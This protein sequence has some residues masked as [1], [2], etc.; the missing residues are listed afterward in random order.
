MKKVLCIVLATLALTGTGG[1]AHARWTPFRKKAPAAEKAAPAPKK[2]PYEKFLDKKGTER[3]EGFLTIYRQ[4]EHIFLEIPENLM[5]KRIL[6]STVV[7]RS[8]DRAVPDGENLSTEPVYRI[9]RTDSLLLLTRATRPVLVADSDSSLSKAV[10]RSRTDAVALAFPIRYRNADSSAVV[11]QADKLFDP[12]GRDVVSFKGRRFSH[13]TISSANYNA[14]LSAL[15]GIRA[16]ERSVGV[17]RE[18]TFDMKLSYMGFEIVGDPKYSAEI[19]TCLTL[20]PESGLRPLKADRRIGVRT[21]SA[22]TLDAAAGIKEEKWASRWHVTPSRKIRIYVDT[23]FTAPWYEAIRKGL[24]AWNGPFI[25]SGLGE[26]VQVEPYPADGSFQAG[27]PL[28]STV[29]V[30]RG[31]SVAAHICTDPLTGEILSCKVTVPDD[32]TEEIRKEGIIHIS[33]VDPRYRSYNLPEEA[34]AEALTA[35]VMSIFGRCLGLAQNLAGSY[36][37]TP[38]QLRDPEFTR[39]NGITASVTDDVLF[40]LLARPGDRER[41]VVTVVDR[42]GACDRYA[43]RWLYDDKLDREDW[44]RRFGKKNAA[45]YIESTRLNADPRAI[46][47]D[48]GNDPFALYEIGCERMRWVAAHAHE[49]IAGAE[50]PDAFRTLFVEYIWLGH[51]RYS[52]VLSRQ[53]GGLMGTDLREG[54]HGQKWT[55]VPVE[56]QRKALQTLIE[57]WSDLSWLDANRELLTLCGPNNNLSNLSRINAFVRSGLGSRLS[58]VAMGETEAEGGYTVAGALRDAEEIL[59]RNIRAGRPLRSGEEMLIATYVAML[60]QQSPVMAA[61]QAAVTHKGNSLTVSAVPAAYTGSVETEA[62][63]ALMRL[64]QV[65]KRAYTRYTGL[66][67]GRIAYILNI[68]DGALESRK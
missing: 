61:N 24:V 1:T 42:I 63:E 15:K 16:Y 40:N 37:Y 50:V 31:A 43:L 22:P 53:I 66:E 9:E 30:G 62:Q 47:G 8:D 68:V 20:L 33:D 46:A 27:D 54:Y 13:Y 34:V 12:S 39:K 65:L 67:K 14:S 19:E 36:A 58:L 51:A 32:F 2:T 21:V 18:A 60:T 23:L 11:I 48:L 35:K 6:L 25:E 10:A 26:A 45:R 56:T 64:Q 57:S 59:T 29:T 55:A 41:G 44:I 38:A 49:W 3:E 4:D 17:V 28:V 52:T 7:R 5:G